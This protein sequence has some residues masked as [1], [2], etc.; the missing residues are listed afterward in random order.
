MTQT[1]H[2]HLGKVFISH[3]AKDK[4][5]VRRL[6]AR[7]AEAGYDVWLDEHALV[8]GDPLAA[9]VGEALKKAKVVLVVV[10][11]TSVVSRWLR[12]ELNVAT[13]RMIKGECRVIP[14]VIDDTELPPEVLGV[15]SA[16]CRRSLRAGWKQIETALAYEAKRSLENQSFYLQVERLLKRFFSVGYLHSLAEYGDESFDVV[17][18]DIKDEHGN[19]I[20]VPY[21][22][23]D[24][25]GDE[26]KP[27]GDRW[28]EAYSDA[29]D[30]IPHPYSLVVSNRPIAFPLDSVH[31]ETPRV[32]FRRAAG[33]G[34]LMREHDVLVVDLSAVE[35]ELERRRLV[36]M[37]R[38]FLVEHAQRRFGPHAS[39]ALD[40]ASGDRV[41]A[42]PRGEA[43]TKRRAASA[44]VNRAAKA[45]KGS[46]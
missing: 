8:V 34:W 10:S 36:G 30:R 29:T 33:S 43:K 4:P 18:L 41:T 16:D 7:I 39:S 17:W 27:L 38:S 19:D 28:W 6:V 46:R 23:I 35:E 3:T 37:A 9:T 12:Y 22:S 5:F 25:Y 21:D 1:R 14:V 44:A 13:E 2:S 20:H 26:I 45:A 40:A 31:P 15:L 11:R 32:G 42:K 24:A